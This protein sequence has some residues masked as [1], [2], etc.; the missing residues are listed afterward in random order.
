[1]VMIFST[2]KVLSLLRMF[3]EVGNLVQLFLNC[4]DQIAYFLRFHILFIFG[5]A[6][7]YKLLGADFNLEENY[8]NV[9]TF[10]RFLLEAI[11]NSVGDI[12]TP[13]YEI[14]NNKLEEDSFKSNFMISL[15]W[16]I[17]VV[18]NILIL[19]VVLMNFLIAIV[20]K[21]FLDVMDNSTNQTFMFRS[22]LN[23]ECTTT[24]NEEDVESSFDIIYMALK[25]DDYN[26]AQDTVSQ[27]LINMKENIIEFMNAKISSSHNDV[28]N[29]VDT[30]KEK[31]HGEMT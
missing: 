18:V 24:F 21:T 20:C 2:L 28:R 1:M 14:W 4:M 3:K 6:S 16:S 31:L 7:V 27:V 15:I 5:T 17:F 11:Q 26:Q 22:L 19:S 23:I 13:S 29:Q 10:F 9:N 30:M 25:S 8:S 12:I